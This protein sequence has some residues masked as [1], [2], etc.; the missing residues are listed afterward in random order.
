MIWLSILSTIVS[1]AGITV[2]HAKPSKAQ[3]I[4]S[5]II[6][7]VTNGLTASWVTKI[8][9]SSIPFSDSIYLIAFIIVSFLVCPPVIMLI[10]SVNSICFFNKSLVYETH[11]SGQSTI[12]WSILLLTQN[13]STVWTIIGLLPICKNCF[14]L[15]TFPMRLPIPP[16]NITP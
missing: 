13:F 10:L 9:L 1:V 7:W 6:L 15:S 8:V 2:S 14:G 3:L 12:T 16:A 5:S 11:C 4:L